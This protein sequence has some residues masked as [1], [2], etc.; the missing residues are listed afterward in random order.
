MFQV[1]RGAYMLLRVLS[2]TEDQEAQG[3]LDEIQQQPD[4]TCPEWP[5]EFL[6]D[7]CSTES[8][9]RVVRAARTKQENNGKERA[10]HV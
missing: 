9:S 7:G 2:T 3:L 10:E 8:V 4:G 5:A 1:L 6:A